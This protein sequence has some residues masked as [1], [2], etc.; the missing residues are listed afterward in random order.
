MSAP[1]TPD[2]NACQDCGH[3]WHDGG[4]TAGD[5]LCQV[6]IMGADGVLRACGC[7]YQRYG[8][9]GRC[10]AHERKE[11]GGPHEWGCHKPAGHD[12]PCST[13]WDCGV[14]FV[15]PE[16]YKVICGNAPSKTG[17][18]CERHV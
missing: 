9:P 11:Y 7:G 14:R 3:P 6:Q 15:G 10:T 13:H 4:L 17:G 18:P 2:E 16:G 12:G 5:C 8:S 1:Q